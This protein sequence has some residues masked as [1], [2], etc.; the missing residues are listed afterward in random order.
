MN[1]RAPQE[2]FIP[3]DPGKFA[4]TLNAARQIAGQIREEVVQSS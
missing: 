3:I 4:C 1:L 2:L